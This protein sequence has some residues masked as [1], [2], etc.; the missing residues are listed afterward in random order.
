MGNFQPVRSGVAALADPN[1]PAWYALREDA[2]GGGFL[3]GHET[4]LVGTPLQR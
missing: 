3:T 4:F 1:S 2:I